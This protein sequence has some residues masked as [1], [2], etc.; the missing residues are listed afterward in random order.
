S[1]VCL[2]SLA[3]PAPLLA[4]VFPWGREDATRTAGDSSTTANGVLYGAA[5]KKS[6]QR[7]DKTVVVWFDACTVVKVVEEEG[8]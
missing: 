3:R 6:E 1:G 7:E 5:Q 4:A 8:G 2:R